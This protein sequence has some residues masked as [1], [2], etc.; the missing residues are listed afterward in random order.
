[1][2]LETIASAIAKYV[3]HLLKRPLMKHENQHVK[4]VVSRL[5]FPT[6]DEK[7]LAKSCKLV[8]EHLL[9]HFRNPTPQDETE[10]V[11][12]FMMKTIMTSDRQDSTIAAAAKEKDKEVIPLHIA[13][14]IIPKNDLKRTYLYLSTE[15]AK[16]SSDH[17]YRTWKISSVETKE[18]ETARILHDAGAIHYMRLLPFPW[19]VDIGGFGVDQS[20]SKRFERV[21]ICMEEFSSV[22]AVLN[23]GR[24]YHWYFKTQQEEIPS[25]ETLPENVYTDIEC[26]PE[27]D[28]MDLFHFPEPVNL[29]TL[30]MSVGVPDDLRAVEN[31]F[32]FEIYYRSDE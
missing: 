9:K 4:L 11:E 5:K 22:A 12:E 19:M 17:F 18:S 21:T 24:K 26:F 14:T 28:N 2:S 30:T 10:S 16:F 23:S 1:M 20:I 31:D 15:V 6:D 13:V 3:S 7:K 8:A 29:R 32:R 25:D 27:G